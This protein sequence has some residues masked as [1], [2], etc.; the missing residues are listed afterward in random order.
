[1]K[2]LVDTHRLALYVEGDP[3]ISSSSSSSRRFCLVARQYDTDVTDAGRFCNTGPHKH[4]HLE[5]ASAW[6]INQ[7]PSNELCRDI[8]CGVYRSVV[9]ISTC[10]P[11]TLLNNHKFLH[12]H[13]YTCSQLIDCATATHQSRRWLGHHQTNPAAKQQAH[14]T[15]RSVAETIVEL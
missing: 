2:L 9:K 3:T 15:G 1:V 7:H 14:R 11:P 10:T 12:H 6:S 4:L 8:Q 5:P 13:H